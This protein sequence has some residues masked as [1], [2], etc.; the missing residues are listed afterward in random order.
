ML[1]AAY[2]L[3]LSLECPQLPRVSIVGLLVGRIYRLANTCLADLAKACLD[4]LLITAHVPEL[5]HP[6]NH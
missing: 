2:F 1:L 3:R 4:G 6:N 5:A